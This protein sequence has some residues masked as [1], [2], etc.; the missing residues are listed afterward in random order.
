MNRKTVRQIQIGPIAIGGEAPI[1][2]QSMTNTKTQDT[3]AFP[4]FL[5]PL[6]TK[7]HSFLATFGQKKHSSSEAQLGFLLQTV[8]K[9]L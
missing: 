6:Q 7:K 8:D 1:S 5:D 3:V 4:V 2:V 9:F